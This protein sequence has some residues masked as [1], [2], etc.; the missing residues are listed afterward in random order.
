[1]ARAI[2][3]RNAG[4]VETRRIR[5]DTTS[6]RRREQH[7]TETERH[8]RKRTTNL[9]G[10]IYIRT[11]I[12]EQRLSPMTP[13]FGPNSLPLVLR[14]ILGEGVNQH[15]KH[16]WPETDRFYLKISGKRLLSTKNYV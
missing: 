3:N 6:E 11:S 10:N 2:V 9:T 16:A 8:L 5:R 7:K 4:Y 12:R 1:M 13:A 14:N 15:T